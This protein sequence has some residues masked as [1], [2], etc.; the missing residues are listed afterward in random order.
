LAGG[1]ILVGTATE[2]EF[3]EVFL[4]VFHNFLDEFVLG[5]FC[6]VVDGIF[7][8]GDGVLALVIG[9]GVGAEFGD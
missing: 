7:E 3:L 4:G 5:C 1:I 6:P 8:A 2:L 9:S